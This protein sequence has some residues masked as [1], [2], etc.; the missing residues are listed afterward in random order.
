MDNYDPVI[1]NMKRFE[2][3]FLVLQVPL[4][5]LFLLL[6]GILAYWLRFSPWAVAVKP[7]MFGLSFGDYL[8]I[9]VI[10][11]LSWLILF[12]LSGLYEPDPNRRFAADVRR[13]F[14]ACSA[15]VAGIALYLLFT[16]SQFDSRFLVAVGWG[17]A[18]FFVAS[19]RLLMRGIKS[20][21]YRIGYGARRV[22]II[23][24]NTLA[25]TLSQMMNTRKELGYIVSGVF[26]AWAEAR[27]AMAQKDID[28][29]IFT[30]PREAEN[31][32]IEAIRFCT[33]HH[34]VFKYSAD[35]FATF[36]TNLSVQPLAGIPIVEIKRTPLEGWGRVVKRCVDVGGSIFFIILTSPLM[37]LV[38][39]F[40]LIET[41]RPVIYKN[42]R[43]GPKDK[44]FFAFKF[45]SMY[46][47]DCTGPQFG[48]EGA[49]AER[50][51][52]PLIQSQS[53]KDGPVYK[54]ANDPRVTPLGKWLR[55][56]S[57][58]ELPQFFNVLLGQMSL[59]GPRPHQPREVQRYHPE[60]RK[61]F[62]IK[63]GITGLA[64]IS[65][66]SDLSFDE[67]VRL[68]VFYIE[69]WSL[70][71]DFIILIKTPFVLFRKR[72]AL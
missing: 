56:F 25:Q 33:E 40:I 20:V 72:K 26:P 49:L 69:H 1:T 51:E 8:P 63:P 53:I 57:L 16:Q 5:F 32:A 41:G 58:D 28:E 14:L 38:G 11:A 54:I 15:G 2:L 47:K 42:E 27:Q 48:V 68:D 10:V 45:R 9:V 3:F 60:H 17:L 6:A 52:E 22:F 29:I 67:E 12:A 31:D 23:G 36:A 24:Q 21:C 44:R 64:Q 7:V 19:G 71:L 46:Q 55:R 13:I 35:L 37:A 70:W 61:V 4:D 62:A 65:G 50:R 59:V 34:V 43:I 39:L 30:N 66:R 18:M